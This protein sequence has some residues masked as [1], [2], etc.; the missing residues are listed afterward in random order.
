MRALPV[1]Q[2]QELRPAAS[3]ETKRSS[4]MELSPYTYDSQ[5]L[6]KTV[7]SVHQSEDE[8]TAAAE[9]RNDYPCNAR[10]RWYWMNKSS[11]Y[12]SQLK[13]LGLTK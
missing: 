11:K 7:K 9:K 1:F 12:Q 8:S 2:F 6:S 5:I 10:H 4:A 13:H 3:I